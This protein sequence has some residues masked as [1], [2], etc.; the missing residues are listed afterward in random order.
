WGAAALHP[1]MR[2]LE[3]PSQDLRTRL[4]K[5]RLALLALACLVAPGIRVAQQFHNADVLVVIAASAALFL[6]V[7][8]RMAGLVRQEERAVS[9]E[10]ALRGA[11]AELVA[12]AGREQVHE[13]AI[14][15]VGALLG[16]GT[17][18][19]LAL[20]GESGAHVA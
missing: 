13:A 9:R 16:D 11:G 17:R 5:V 20:F 6:L 1:S 14:S 7:V 3:E 18:A 19:R 12:A 15:A 2:T 4:T 8:T 10:R